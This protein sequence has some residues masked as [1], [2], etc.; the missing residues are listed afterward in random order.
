MLPGDYLTVQ[1]V[2]LNILVE[3]LIAHH[4][5]REAVRATV[6]QLF[7]QLQA[8][9]L[10]SGVASPESL[11]VVRETIERVFAPP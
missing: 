7:G 1:I 9:G 3:A 8:S 11:A 4:P 10:A 5:N 6:D 2:A